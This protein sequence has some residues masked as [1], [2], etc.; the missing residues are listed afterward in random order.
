MCMSVHMYTML[1]R[2]HA[3]M[4]LCTHHIW[5]VMLV[6]HCCTI[7]STGT[8]VWLRDAETILVVI[9]NSEILLPIQMVYSTRKNKVS[10]R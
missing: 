2:V 5:K 7:V 1:Q 10:E 9:N 4:K 6:Q 3:A 8:R